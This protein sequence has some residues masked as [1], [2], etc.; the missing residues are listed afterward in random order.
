MISQAI[1]DDNPPPGREP[2]EILIVDG[3]GHCG[4]GLETMIEAAGHH[5]SVV[6]TC[7]DAIGNITGRRFDLVFLE[8]HLPDC[9]DSLPGKKFTMINEIFI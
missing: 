3:D 8:I 4:S 5:A 9:N 1:V 6:R 2:L 7:S